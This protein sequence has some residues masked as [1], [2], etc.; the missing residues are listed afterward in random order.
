[1]IFDSIEKVRPELMD[2]TEKPSKADVE[3]WCELNGTRLHQSLRE[4][5]ECYGTGTVFETRNFIRQL[6]IPTQENQLVRSI[7]ICGT[8]V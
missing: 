4:L 5:W 6:L 8:E 1:M 7:N 3:L 2:F